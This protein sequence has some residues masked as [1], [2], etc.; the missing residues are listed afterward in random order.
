MWIPSHSDIKGNGRADE[1]SQENGN[2][3]ELGATI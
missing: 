1:E 3:S 2:E